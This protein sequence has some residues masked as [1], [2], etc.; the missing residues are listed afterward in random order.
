ML[1]LYL[2]LKW[3]TKCGI[4]LAA[5]LVM[6]VRKENNKAWA[7]VC[8]KCILLSMHLFAAWFVARV[9]HEVWA[10][11]FLESPCFV[12]SRCT[13]WSDA[14]FYILLLLGVRWSGVS[15]ITFFSELLILLLAE[16]SH[17][18]RVILESSLN[19]CKKK[20]RW[21]TGPSFSLFALCAVHTILGDKKHAKL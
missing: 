13:L 15:C 12:F 9:Q 19:K 7:C 1:A 16:L 2:K 18:L 5:I 17:A 21:Y 3:C 11:L 14:N 10:Q 6:E 4:Q 8:L 20:L